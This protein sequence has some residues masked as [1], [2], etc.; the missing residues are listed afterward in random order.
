MP[1]KELNSNSDKYIYLLDYAILDVF[2]KEK[3]DIR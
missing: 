3:V 2:Y 1:Y